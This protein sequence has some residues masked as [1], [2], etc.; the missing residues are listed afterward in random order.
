[1]IFEVTADDIAALGDDPLRRL[2]ALLAEQELV[3]RDLS[4]SAVLSGG[5]QNAKDGGIDVRVELGDGAVLC[6]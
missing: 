4:P 6:P 3:R 5:D 2:V 1:M